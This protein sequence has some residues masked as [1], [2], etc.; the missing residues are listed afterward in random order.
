VTQRS[1][2]LL[3]P[4]FGEVAVSSTRLSVPGRDDYLIVLL[5]PAAEASAAVMD[6][7]WDGNARRP[8]RRTAA[9]RGPLTRRQN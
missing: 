5:P 2:R 3:I 9:P 8:A 1:I 6:R 7:L 4:Q